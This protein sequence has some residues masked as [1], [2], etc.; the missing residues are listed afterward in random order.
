MKNRVKT[1]GDVRCSRVP[2]RPEVVMMI[3][4]YDDSGDGGDIN[5]DV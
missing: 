2:S 1:G 4:K 5:D 3:N